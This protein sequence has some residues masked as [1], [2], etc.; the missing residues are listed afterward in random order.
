MRIISSNVPIGTVSAAF[1]ISD[2]SPKNLKFKSGKCIA[3]HGFKS[4]D[5]IREMVIECKLFAVDPMNKKVQVG[6]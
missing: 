5:Q 3:T 1:R 2:S 4:R 6:V